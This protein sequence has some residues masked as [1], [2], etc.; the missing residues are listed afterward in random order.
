[1]A[2]QKY[3]PN[4]FKPKAVRLKNRLNNDIIEGILVKEDYIDGKGYFVIK[5]LNG[6][7]NKFSKE[8]YTVMGNSLR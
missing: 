4:S 5:F 3:A 1:M 2:G 7:V 6:A 8:A